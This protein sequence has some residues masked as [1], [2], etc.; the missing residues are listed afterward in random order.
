MDIWDR[1]E[2]LDKKYAQSSQAEKMSRIETYEVRSST[3]VNFQFSPLFQTVADFFLTGYI[4]FKS[5]Y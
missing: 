3:K 5:A 1:V 4:T 2:S